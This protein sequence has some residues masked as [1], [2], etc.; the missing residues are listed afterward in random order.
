MSSSSARHDTLWLV[1]RASRGLYHASSDILCPETNRPEW[2]P[3]R[4][5]GL[6]KDGTKWHSK[7]NREEAG[8]DVGTC[9]LILDVENMKWI[10]K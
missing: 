10:G 6:T 1:V 4:D 5:E 2:A 8:A 7:E 3:G 9:S